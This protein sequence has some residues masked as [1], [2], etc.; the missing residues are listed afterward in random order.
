MFAGTVWP[1]A[2]KFGTLT[3]VKDGRVFMGLAMW[4]LADTLSPI[5]VVVNVLRI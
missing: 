3:D 5:D 4:V 2:N 1:T